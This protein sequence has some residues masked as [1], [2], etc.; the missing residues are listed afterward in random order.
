MATI[1]PARPHRRATDG[2]S[3]PRKHIDKLLSAAIGFVCAVLYA[4]AP[5]PLPGAGGEREREQPQ[6]Q[7]HYQGQVV[8]A[9][10]VER[11]AVLE[12]KVDNLAVAVRDMTQ[13]LESQRGRK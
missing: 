12:T 13:R 8:P 5:L 3:V 4:M 2:Y 10:V 1:T 9:A 7:A 11:I 6:L